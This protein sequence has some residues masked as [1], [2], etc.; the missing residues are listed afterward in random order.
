MDEQEALDKR[1]AELRRSLE[2]Q[3]ETQTLL[4]TQLRKAEVCVCVCVC[5]V[6]VCVCTYVCVC[7]FL[8]GY[9]A[10]IVVRE[11]LTKVIIFLLH[12]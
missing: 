9:D 3:R 2:E 12:P 10:Q 1:L 4:A 7:V 6:Y 8:E 5:C 11:S